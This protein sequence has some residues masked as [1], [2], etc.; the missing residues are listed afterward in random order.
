MEKNNS[1]QHRS[2]LVTGNAE[3][4]PSLPIPSSRALDAVGTLKAPGR[5]S[6]SCTGDHWLREQLLVSRTEQRGRG[7]SLS[8]VAAH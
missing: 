2:G 8:R 4:C 5:V 7:I 3:A 1:E 6:H